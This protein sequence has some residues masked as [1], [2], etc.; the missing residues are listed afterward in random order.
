MF[1]RVAV[2]VDYNEAYELHPLR[3]H[4]G[5]SGDGQTRGEDTDF[6]LHALSRGWRVGRFPELR[7]T[8]LIPAGRLTADYM[9]RLLEGVAAGLVLNAEIYG[10]PKPYPGLLKRWI[11][12]LRIRRLPQPERTFAQGEADG[13]ERGIRIVRAYRSGIH[14][15]ISASACNLGETCNV[16]GMS[17]SNFLRQV[18]SFAA[19]GLFLALSGCMKATPQNLGRSNEPLPD[20]VR[21]A[22]VGGGCFWC[23]EAVYERVPGVLAVVSGYA[24]GHVANPT[25]EQIS[26]GNTGHAE[27]IQIAYD[28][29]RISYRQLI[30]L[31]WDAHDPTTLNRQGADVGPQY[32]S[33][34]LY[35][36]EQERVEAIASRD[37]AQSRFRSPIVTE[38]KA[39]ETF[40]PAE[41]YHQD[42]FMNNPGHGYSRAVIRPKVERLTDKGLLP[43]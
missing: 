43:H 34:I 4:L 12:R 22:V 26:R 32:R 30:D 31:F 36:N 16:D 18:A 11:H 27:V 9:G 39:L 23:T 25:Y 10:L 15:R 2:A 40:Y 14:R 7:L 1:T 37:A 28:P 38:I 13:I 6:V 8:Y 24:G 33:I 20:G 35:A 19:V 29:A 3:I 17:P 42:F 41:E 5:V 21:F